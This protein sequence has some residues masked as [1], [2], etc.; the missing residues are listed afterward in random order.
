[1]KTKKKMCE[2][3]KELLCS[4][5]RYSCTTISA[6]IPPP[7]PP[8]RPRHSRAPS[9]DERCR[10][11]MIFLRRNAGKQNLE[12]IHEKN[13]FMRRRVAVLPCICACAYARACACVDCVRCRSASCM[14]GEFTSN[15]HLQTVSPRPLL[16][17]SPRPPFL[18]PPFL[19]S[20]LTARLLLNPILSFPRPSAPLFPSPLLSSPTLPS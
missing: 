14:P 15:T 12:M 5:P 6:C 19:S 1:M 3:Q 16:L 2:E 17:S 4:R 13:N 10:D 11:A 7:P 20:P 9:F 18:V 8:T